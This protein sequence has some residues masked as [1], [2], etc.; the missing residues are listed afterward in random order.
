AGLLGCSVVVAVTL[1][2]AWALTLLVDTPVRRWRWANARP[3]RAGAVVA[4]ALVLGLGPSLGA[5]VLL[6]RA[7]DE[8]ERRAVADNP[9]ARVLD[10][11]FVPHPDADPDA[12]PIPHAAELRSDW[13]LLDGPC[14]GALAPEDPSV[15]EGCQMT[16]ADEDAKVIVAVGNSRMRQAVMAL[17][18]PAARNGW[19]VV[20]VHK[21][22]CQYQPGTMT[23]SGQECFDHNL[24]VQEYLRELQPEAVM[25]TS[26]VYRGVG[27]ETVS[28][29]LDEEVPELLGLGIDVVA[30]RTAEG[31]TTPLDPTHLPVE[32]TDASRLAEI[33]VSETPG[34]L[35]AADL[36]PVLC[37]EHECRPLIGNT[38]VFLDR[39][40]ISATYMRST[41]GEL[42]R[43]LE[44]SGFAW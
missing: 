44:E 22:S 41:G 38:W 36:L 3:L 29:V 40:H 37:P 9:G 20:L 28:P 42:G 25:V 4:L 34:T 24:A 12:A 19:R 15:A 39:H 2:L 23:Y 33:S 7:A 31:C 6:Q 13:G 32:R 17:L 21:N 14:E 11:S 16:E 35:Y 10:P 5:Q 30:L 26:T 18:E 43:Q 27:P 1:V 8:A